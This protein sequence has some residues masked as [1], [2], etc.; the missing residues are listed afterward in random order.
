MSNIVS[1]NHRLLHNTQAFTQTRYDAVSRS[2]ARTAFEVVFIAS[3]SASAVIV[4]VVAA[5]AI[6]AAAASF[7][8]T[9]YDGVSRAEERS[10]EVRRSGVDGAQLAR[11]HSVLSAM[12]MRALSISL[13]LFLSLSLSLFISR[14]TSVYVRFRRVCSADRC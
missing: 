11:F 14:S 4:M 1:A 10:D 13:S 8:Q 7:T 2:N 9:Q 12:S 3:T 5:A 6:V